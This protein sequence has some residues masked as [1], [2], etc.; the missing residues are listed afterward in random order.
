MTACRRLYLEAYTMGIAELR[1]SVDAPGDTTPR[2]VPLRER[3]ER[4]SQQAARL[5][6]LDCQALQLEGPLSMTLPGGPQGL[7]KLNGLYYAVN[8]RTK[9]CALRSSISSFHA[10]HTISYRVEGKALKSLK[11]LKKAYLYKE[12]SVVFVFVAAFWGGRFLAI[13]A[14]PPPQDL[15]EAF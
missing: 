11:A 13:L 12:P 2:V 5:S 7:Q 10:R 9:P 8:G 15:P 14:F 4:Q 3:E 1:R 6:G